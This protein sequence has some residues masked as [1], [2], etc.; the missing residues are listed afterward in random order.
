MGSFTTGEKLVSQIQVKSNE[1]SEGNLLSIDIKSMYEV[2]RTG[3]IF[4]GKDEYPGQSNHAINYQGLTDGAA[5]TFEQ[6]AMVNNFEKM[7]LSLMNYDAVNVAQKL[8]LGLSGNNLSIMAAT[9][10]FPSASL[11]VNGIRLF[12]YEQPSFSTHG[13]DLV[14]YREPMSRSNGGVIPVFEG[15]KPAPNFYTR[16]AR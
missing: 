5:V 3:G 15:R 13:R 4:K 12:R 6:H 10:I 9:D 1:D 8:T 16:Y 7:G 11:D 14:G 2:R